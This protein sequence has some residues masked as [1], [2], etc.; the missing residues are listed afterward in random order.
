MRLAC[1]FVAA[2]VL[3]GAPA[4]AA[5][6][7]A[8]TALTAELDRILADPRLAGA[9][10]AVDALARLGADPK[11]VTLGDG[12]ALSRGNWITARQLTTVLTATRKRP[13]FPDLHASPPVAGD[14]APL[15]GGTLRDRKAAHR[16]AD[17][18]R[19]QSAL[20]SGACLPNARPAI[21]EPRDPGPADAAGTRRP[22]R[23]GGAGP[24]RRP[25]GTDP[26]H[27][28]RGALEPAR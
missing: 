9:T 18:N 10:V 5:D 13:W 23:A 8:D 15:V 28:V 2:F 7:R 11:V 22:D 16:K 1:A 20:P 3:A 17:R 6:P 12:S 19:P 27:L 25:A 4:A 21:P 24:T 26:A 14:P